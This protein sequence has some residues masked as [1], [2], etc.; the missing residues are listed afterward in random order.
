MGYWDYFIGQQTWKDCVNNRDLIKGFE[1]AIA[2]S[3]ANKMQLALS[4]SSYRIASDM[5]LGA[6]TSEVNYGLQQLT[7]SIEFDLDQLKGGIDKL[8]ADF[9][10]LIGD[11]IWRLELQEKALKD[12]LQEIRLAEFEREARAY[13]ESG[14]DAYRNGW[15]DDALREFIEAEKRNFKDFAVQRSIAHIYF[16]YLADLPKALEYFCKSAKYAKPRDVR[17][18]AEAEYFA[19]VACGILQQFPEALAHA[20]TAT[21]LNPQLYEAFYLQASVAAIIG[22]IAIVTNSLESAVIGD[23]RY[24]E[25][26]KDD[27]IFARIRSSV[28]AVLNNLLEKERRDTQQKLSEL[29]RVVDMAKRLGAGKDI[30]ECA[31]EVSVLEERCRQSNIFVYRSLATEAQRWR[32]IA[33]QAAEKAVK[34]QIATKENCISELK[35]VKQQIIRSLDDSFGRRRNDPRNTT[36][37]PLNV[38]CGT[39]AAFAGGF[40]ILMAMIWSSIDSQLD[41]KGRAI[42]IWTTILGTIIAPFISTS[43]LNLFGKMSHAI[44]KSAYESE[45]EVERHNTANQKSNAEEEYKEKLAKPERELS[46]LK[47]LLLKLQRRQI[48]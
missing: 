47:S 26:A 43:L 20:R 19:G 13:R 2:K 42:I 7:D 30:I 11:M 44:G 38:G 31:Y 3:E 6:L 1:K 29:K 41:P 10:L 14:E 21:E 4:Q 9:N 37:E 27:E 23:L 46:D 48:G 36:Y 16:Y 24:Y 15:Y 39:Y 22:N 18:S 33:F 32:E 45:M 28:Q 12:L 8:N 35:E 40:F 34:E 25:R 17:Q 5:G